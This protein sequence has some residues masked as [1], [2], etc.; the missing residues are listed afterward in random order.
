LPGAAIRTSSPPTV[1]RWELFG[2]GRGGRPAAVDWMRCRG[3]AGSV[4]AGARG[5]NVPV[6]AQFWEIVTGPRLLICSFAAK[7][8]P[9]AQGPPTDRERDERLLGHYL[10]SLSGKFPGRHD[11]LAARQRGNTGRNSTRLDGFSAGCCC[12]WQR[13]EDTIAEG[14]SW[15]GRR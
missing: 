6:P 8:G 2:R 5:C 3:S 11:G 10:N 12:D 13:R 4:L 15:A 14:G 9:T 7:L 1:V